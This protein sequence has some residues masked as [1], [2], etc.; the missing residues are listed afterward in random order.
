MKTYQVTLVRTVY[1]NYTIEANTEEEAEALAWEHL[2]NDPEAG[3]GDGE[4]DCDI[5]EEEKA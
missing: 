3:T 5:I 4:W 1:E 2:E